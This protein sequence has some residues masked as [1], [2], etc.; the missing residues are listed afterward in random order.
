MTRTKP[1]S[2]KKHKLETFLIK[3]EN[4][5]KK[6]E[7]TRERVEVQGKTKVQTKM[8]T[9][10]LNDVMKPIQK[11]QLKNNHQKK[12]YVT[13][14]TNQML[15]YLCLYETT[16]SMILSTIETSIERFLYIL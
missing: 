5:K 3:E 1:K 16:Q 10:E 12:E 14:A 6:Q 8:M 2:K 13:V 7:W 4:K 15:T 9:V 11:K